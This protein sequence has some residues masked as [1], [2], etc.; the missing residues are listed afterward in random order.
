MELTTKGSDKF[1]DVVYVMDKK[2]FDIYTKI[3]DGD[4][5]N[6]SDDK[7]ILGFVYRDGKVS[8][9]ES[10]TPIKYSELT[11]ETLESYTSRGEVVFALSSIKYY[12]WAQY[13]EPRIFSI[14]KILAPNLCIGVLE[15]SM[16]GKV[17][18]EGE[19]EYYFIS[20]NTRGKHQY[21]I[22]SI[23]RI[24]YIQTNV[25]ADAPED[26]ES[27]YAIYDNTIILSP[28]EK[29]DSD[30]EV[31]TSSSDR[32]TIWIFDKRDGYCDGYSNQEGKEVYVNAN[33]VK[34]EYS[35]AM[36]PVKSENK[37]PVEGCLVIGGK[38]F[39]TEYVSYV[40]Y[41]GEYFTVDNR[42][43]QDYGDGECELYSD[44]DSYNGKFYRLVMHRKDNGTGSLT[45]DIEYD[46]DE[47]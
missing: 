22:S 13:S 14:R 35:V 46:E 45:I 26:I 36:C 11:Q 32:S 34:N 38:L 44:F 17:G 19:N 2:R 47:E 3:L 16:D 23:E 28:D 37:T 30:G 39:D 41:D 7:K 21:G 1:T 15:F 20:F 12:G 43:V 4:T 27:R 5:I 42:K 33:G 8:V 25:Y 6:Q 29:I 9:L 10:A 24:E 31:A 40:T 18:R